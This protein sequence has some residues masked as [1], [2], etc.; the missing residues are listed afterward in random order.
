MPETAP[1]PETTRAVFRVAVSWDADVFEEMSREDDGETTS[2][3]SSKTFSEA[4]RE[5]SLVLKTTSFDRVLD[6]PGEAEDGDSSCEISSG[7]DASFAESLTAFSTEL[8]GVAEDATGEFG[9]DCCA[10]VSVFSSLFLATMAAQREQIAAP[11]KRGARCKSMP[12]RPQNEQRASRRR[13][14]RM[15]L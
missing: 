12:C 11:A 9:E 3:R 13:S 8:C 7:V 5:R 10:S 15:R 2:L 4:A 14:D 6:V 1:T